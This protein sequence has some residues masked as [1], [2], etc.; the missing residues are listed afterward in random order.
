MKQALGSQE[1]VER[2]MLA[3]IERT[4]GT[5]QKKERFIEAQIPELQLRNKFSS[6]SKKDFSFKLSFDQNC[7]SDIDK[8]ILRTSPEI[9]DISRTVLETSL[10][11]L[12][13]NHPLKVASR[14]GVMRTKIIEKRTSVILGRFRYLL[15]EEKEEEASLV[16]EILPI[17]FEGSPS[18]FSKNEVNFGESAELI[19]SKAQPEAN[20]TVAERDRFLKPLIDAASHICNE[21]SLWQKEKRIN[22]ILETHKRVRS[23]GTIRRLKVEC[24]GIPDVLGVYVFLPVVNWN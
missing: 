11:S 9:E 18:E 12:I 20:V 4:K 6:G 24:V 1:D 19:L 17:L 5:Y 3:L 8:L 2:F 13:K 14:A 23:Q 7:L 22:D 15:R 16:E 21:L 10:D